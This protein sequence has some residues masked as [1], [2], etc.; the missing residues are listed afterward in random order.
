MMTPNRWNSWL[1]VALVGF[2]AVGCLQAEFG[3]LRV[4]QRSFAP[5]NIEVDDQQVIV[6]VGLAVKL[7]VKPIS[8]N[9]QEY[10]SNDDLE[11]ASDNPSVMD[12]FQIDDSSEVV[13]AGVREGRT[14]LRVVVNRDEVTCLAVRVTQ[15]VVEPE[16]DR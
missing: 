15:Q 13:V 12:A 14:C 1:G 8:G 16:R 10:T 3:D 4:E 2:S 5:L 9:R 7:K 6:P 11:F